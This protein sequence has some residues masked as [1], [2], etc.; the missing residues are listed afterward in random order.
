MQQAHLD[1]TAAL[2]LL[3]GQQQKRIEELEATIEKMR[4]WATEVN[5]WRREEVDE[6]LPKP[7]KQRVKPE[8]KISSGEVERAYRIINKATGR[9]YQRDS[10]Y[11]RDCRKLM[12]AHGV[13]RVCQV[14]AFAVRENAKKNAD[15]WSRPATL[16]RTKNFA[17]WLDEMEARKDG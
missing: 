14:V 10:V 12:A 6:R 1:S 17:R 3:V 16:F 2:A 5:R 15:E 8:T 9:N 13:D 7:R 4:T 11:G